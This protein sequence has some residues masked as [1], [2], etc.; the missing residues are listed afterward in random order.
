VVHPRLP[1][2]TPL[3]RASEVSPAVF[4]VYQGVLHAPSSRAAARPSKGRGEEKGEGEQSFLRRVAAAAEPFA[5]RRSSV[6]GRRAGSEAAP[7]AAADDGLGQGAYVGEMG[8]LRSEAEAADLTCGEGL[9][10]LAAT[11]ECLHEL[12]AVAPTLRAHVALRTVRREG[13]GYESIVR[14]PA[15]RDVLLAH[16]KLEFS[17]EAYLFARDAE[18]WRRSLPPPA[19]RALA[20]TPLAAALAAARS[21]AELYISDGAPQQINISAPCQK[22]VLGAL[23]AG[24]IEASLFDA[25]IDEVRKLVERDTLPRVTRGDALAAV[26]AR[27]GALDAPSQFGS[28]AE[29]DAALAT[30]AVEAKAFPKYSHL[31]AEEIGNWRQYETEM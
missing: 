9:L 29:L 13:L 31:I 3:V 6:E 11:G 17:E 28:E 8:V 27:L 15:S 22:A 30:A 5:I 18:A 16:M 12:L 1:A 23:E 10:C 25:A 4:F 2:G 19:A 21:L 7:A 26:C 24:A 14:H 20:S